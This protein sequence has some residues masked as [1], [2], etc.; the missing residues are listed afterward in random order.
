MENYLRSLRRNEPTKSRLFSIHAENTRRSRFDL[1]NSFFSSKVYNV[2]VS[3]AFFGVAKGSVKLAY[4]SCLF[5]ELISRLIRF[6][7]SQKA[8][9]EFTAEPLTTPQEQEL[10]PFQLQWYLK[11]TT[12]CLQC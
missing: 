7:F 9:Q 6:E 10:L 1:W 2:L 4:Y 12:L 8:E 11:K 5:W 3:I